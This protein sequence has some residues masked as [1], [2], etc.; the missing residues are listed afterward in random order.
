MGFQTYASIYSKSE[1]SHELI[2]V[3]SNKISLIP[4]ALCLLLVCLLV[5]RIVIRCNQWQVQREQSFTGK[6]LQE[7][8]H[9][10]HMLFLRQAISYQSSFTYSPI[11][12]LCLFFLIFN[13]FFMQA[14]IEVPYNLLQA[15]IYRIIV[16]AMVGYEWTV[17]KV[18]WYIFFMFFTF[19]Y[20]TYYGM[21][22]AAMTPTQPMAVLLSS[23]SSSLWNLF[24][25]FI[26]PQP[27]SFSFL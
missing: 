12:K 1:F 14:L 6:G 18:F 20:F 27:V 7:C 24:S 25:G 2:T 11:C 23:A 10:W 9:L 16:Y 21:M 22:T 4:W 13:F 3:K 19:L 8:I 5:S 17:A 15:V 26:V